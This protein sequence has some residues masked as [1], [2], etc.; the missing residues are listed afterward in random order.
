ML[1]QIISTVSVASIS[2]SMVV[3]MQSAHASEKAECEIAINSMMYEAQQYHGVNIENLVTFDSTSIGYP[4]L[5]DVHGNRRETAYSFF[6]E[7]DSNSADFVQS[8]P[9]MKGYAQKVASSCRSLSMISFIMTTEG[10]WNE[11]FGVNEDSK[12]FKFRCVLPSS[13]EANQNPMPWGVKVC[14]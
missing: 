5:V 8:L 4:S 11:T 3:P 7:I 14:S 6:L 12:I 10:P 2:F 1:R 9:I 13:P